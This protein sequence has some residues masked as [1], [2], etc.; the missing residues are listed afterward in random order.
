MMPKGAT[1]QEI[2]VQ[3]MDISEDQESLLE[4]AA[5]LESRL[6][7]IQNCVNAYRSY[8]S[9]QNLP[10]DVE[11]LEVVDALI[12]LVEHR[13]ATCLPVTLN[14]DSELIPYSQQVDHFR[15][16]FRALLHVT[17]TAFTTLDWGAASQK[18][19]Q[20]PMA[21]HIGCPGSD[22]PYVRYGSRR[23]EVLETALKKMLNFDPEKTTLLLT[24]SG[25]SA[26]Q[27]VESY[28][29]RN[30]LSPGDQVLIVGSIYFETK[31]QLTSLPGFNFAQVGTGIPDIQKSI[32]LAKPK[33]IFV[34]PMNNDFELRMVDI[35]KL[36]EYLNSLESQED[37]YLVIDGTMIPDGI[38]PFK[39]IKNPHIKV[40]YYSSC[41]KYLQGGLDLTMAG[42]VAVAPGM[43]HEFQNLRQSTGTILY[44]PSASLLPVLEP[45]VHKKRSVRMT[46]NASILAQALDDCSAVDVRF[47]KLSSHPDR[48]ITSQLSSIGGVLTFCFRESSLNTPDAL[49]RFT[50]ILIES[51]KEHAIPV[52]EGV[53]FGFSHP[54]VTVAYT[55]GPF[56][57][58]R[59]SAG[60]RSF[61]E[62][63]TFCEILL[64]SIREFLE[65]NAKL[66]S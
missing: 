27:L 12:H 11:G 35:P 20:V 43:A 46:R 47:P 40:I 2:D 34:E 33:V 32:S 36:I 9:T 49:E 45:E 54:R 8:C 62:I 29:A 28:L 30:V 53:S 60:D 66:A 39:Y 24:S 21:F 25:M 19:S 52:T 50:D 59:L 55:Q 18:Q 57:Y 4:L 41:G 64:Q 44:E 23:L 31:A 65:L 7:D 1:E 22:I 48:A 61:Q 14:E 13:I 58:L 26:Y 6:D 63:Q 51:A 3:R 5:F 37:L 15:G 38:N 56:S 42:L 10:S 16:I 17:M